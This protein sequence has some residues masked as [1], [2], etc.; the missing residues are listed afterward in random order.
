MAFEMAGSL[1]FQQA[2]RDAGV[3]LLEPVMAVEVR[4]PSGALGSVVGELAARRGQVTAMEPEGATA[5]VGALAPLAELFDYT[6]A[7][8]GTT[9]GRASATV[10]FAHYAEVPAHVAASVAARS[11]G[12]RA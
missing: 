6:N 9:Q 11:R 5:R 4:C 12:G 10:H 2:A 1:A 3:A 7:L 8:R